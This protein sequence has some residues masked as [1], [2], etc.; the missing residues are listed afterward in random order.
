MVWL[1][2]MEKVWWENFDGDFFFD[3]RLKFSVGKIWCKIFDGKFSV[4]KVRWEMSRAQIGASLAQGGKKKI[5]EKEK[6]KECH[7]CAQ[8]QTFPPV[9]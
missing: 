7:G 1:R 4:A 2:F 9:G 6:K 5:I 8:T 3:N